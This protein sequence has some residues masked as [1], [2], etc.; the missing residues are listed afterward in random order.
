MK[1]TKVK[2]PI[3]NFQITM[4]EIEKDDD[5]CCVLG[6]MRK[7]KVEDEE[8][9]T[10]KNEDSSISFIVPTIDSKINIDLTYKAETSFGTWE[11]RTTFDLVNDVSKIP[12]IDDSVDGEDDVVTPEIPETPD[13]NDGNIGSEESNVLADG[14]YTLNNAI[15]K[16]GT[17][18]ESMARGFIEDKTF[19][20]V[21]DGIITMTLKY[22]GLGLTGIRGTSIKVNGVDTSSIVNA[23][24]SVSFEVPSIDSKIEVEMD[25]Y[26]VAAGFSE[27]QSVDFVNDVDSLTKVEDNNLG[28][29]NN[30][31][32]PETPEIPE[33]PE[34]GGNTEDGGNADSDSSN[35]GSTN[36]GNT[37]NQE[38]KVYIGKNEV[39]HENET[40]LSM[41]RQA[42]EEILKVEE[43]NELK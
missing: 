19:I 38:T 9:E 42:L 8:I 41:S 43:I 3:Y 30:G 34:S 7:F 13:N 15:Y 1:I 29:D 40:G 25:I 39:T 6:H 11:H 18:Q 35:N 26:V 36:D 4:L 16:L 27:I 21:K 10:I 2:I 33:T 24:K 23:D 20:T 22:K 12:T 5:E 28:G 31:E 14:N 32:S 17:N 37:E